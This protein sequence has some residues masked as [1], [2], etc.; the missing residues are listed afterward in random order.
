MAAYDA[1][2]EYY[3]RNWAIP[4]SREVLPVLDRLLL[5]RMPADA[6]LLSVCCG[7]GRI[8]RLLTERGCQVTGVDISSGMLQLARRNAP[9]AEFLQADVRQMA[10]PATF[11]GA[12]STYH[13]LNHLTT[14]AGLQDALWNVCAAL[15]GGGV[16]VFDM[17]MDEGY[18]PDLDM[19]V[20]GPHSALLRTGSYDPQTK[21]ARLD[22]CVAWVG[23]DKVARRVEQTL[24]ER[25]YSEGEIRAALEE[26]GFHDI[27]SFDAVRELGMKEGGG[28]RFFTAAR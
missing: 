26:A 2:A 22:L 16:F 3:D 4:F 19:A 21:M 13:A 18:Q 15:V 25:C 5:S 10:L 24:W 1:F 9:R 23:P 27:R 28:R 8:E 14:P 11:H 17:N 6:R 7:T 12:Y 20:A